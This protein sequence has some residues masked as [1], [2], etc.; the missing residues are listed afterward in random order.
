MTLVDSINLPVNKNFEQ[1]FKDCSV[2]ESVPTIDFTNVK[3]SRSMFKIVMELKL[4]MVLLYR[5]KMQ[6]L[7]LKDVILLNM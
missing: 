2:L 4:S 7:C 5:N 6:M 3:V 1:A